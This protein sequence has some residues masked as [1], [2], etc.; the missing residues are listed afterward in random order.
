[1]GPRGGGNKDVA[2]VADGE[3]GADAKRVRPRSWDPKT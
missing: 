3:K 2:L 1:M